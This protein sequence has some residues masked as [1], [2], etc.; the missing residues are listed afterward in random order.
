M[1]GTILQDLNDSHL[2]L[3]DLTDRNANVFYELGVRHALKDRTI[4]I[5]QRKEDIPFD[6][7]AYAYHIYDWKTPGGIQALAEK[8]KA[9]LTEIDDSPERPDNPV[10]DFLR[11]HSPVAGE[12]V[13]EPIAPTEV[14]VA[15]PLVGEAADGLD[16]DNLVRGLVQRAR[17][18]ETKTIMRLTRA[19]LL[20]LTVKT[21]AALNARKSPEPTTREKI[22]EQAKPYIAEVEPLTRNLEVFGLASTNEGWNLGLEVVLKLAGNLVS[23]SERPA[24]GRIVRYAQGAPALM[25]WRMLCLCGA[26]AIDEDELTILKYVLKEPIEVEESTGKFSHRSLISRNDLFYPDAFLGYADH[27]MRY[28]DGLW[29]ETPH[30]KKFFDTNESYQFA[31]AK[32]FIVVVLAGPVEDGHPLYPGYRLLTQARRAMSSVTSR[33]FSSE[34]F[35]KE[36]AGIVGVSSADLVK[37]WPDKAKAINGVNS[38]GWNQF[39]DDVRFPEEFG[40]S[41]D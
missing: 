25:A 23:I 7:Q 13:E 39:R 9:L 33:L 31:L 2:V 6:L 30:L 20:P 8:I 1:V 27:P 38:G 3:A 4:L 37:D 17:P 21:I 22:P 35:R 14:T 32:F 36:I 19:E 15:Q 18:N 16:I 28:M 34:G 29:N 41:S 24:S 40:K 5:A 26:K 10:S 11:V 12:P